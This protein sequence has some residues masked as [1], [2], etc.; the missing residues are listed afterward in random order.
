VLTTRGVVKILDFGLAKLR[1]ERRRSDGLTR[2]NALMGTPEYIAPEQAQDTRS[3]DIRADIY[4]LGCTLFCLLAGRP[5]F[6]GGDWLPIVMAHLQEEP[7]PLERLRP[8]VP[9]EL[10]ALV[11]R[12]LAKDPAQRPQTPKEVAEALLP[13]TRRGANAVAPV[14]NGA[15]VDGPAAPPARN[16]SDRHRWLIPAVA[17]AAVLLGLGVWGIVVSLRTADGTIVVT[18]NEPG[19][20]VFVDG[21][22]IMVTRPGDP[23][24]ITIRKPAGEHLLEIRKGGFTAESVKLTLAAGGREP[25]IVDLRPDV[26]PDAPKPP[27]PQPAPKGVEP[28]F[29]EPKPADPPPALQRVEPKPEEPKSPVAPHASRLNEGFVPLFNGTD[30]TGWKPLLSQ[31]TTWQVENGIL[32]GQNNPA[33]RRGWGG[34]LITNRDNFRNFH[35]RVEV[36]A[37]RNNSEVS[38]RVGPPIGR[39]GGLT[40]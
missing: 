37:G 5:P 30:R 31:T 2:E 19:A 8:D 35:L 23:E 13:F 1:S 6:T 40:G 26:V 7:P 28:R 29:E 10:A 4:A 18:V 33:G 12:M 24:P 21:A 20:E 32:V 15:V 34:L 38:F 16:R 39:D 25:V 9:P 11:A 22:L 36:L 3:A 17:A 27:A 14:D